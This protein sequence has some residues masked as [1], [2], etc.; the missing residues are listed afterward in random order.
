MSSAL[1]VATEVR[2]GDVT[3]LDL[4]PPPSPTESER[5]LRIAEYPFG[6]NAFFSDAIAAARNVF[7]GQVLLSDGSTP[8]WCA[9]V[10]YFQPGDNEPK[11]ARTTDALGQFRPRGTWWMNIPAKP[12]EL[13]GPSEPVVVAFLPGTCG[14]AILPPPERSDQPMRIV[15]PPPIAQ[16]GQVKVGG[17]APTQ[18]NGTIHVKAGY[19]DKGFLNELLSVTTTA[20][21]D[22]NFTLA[23]L[24]PGNYLIQAALDDIWLSPSSA[25]HVTKG[26]PEPIELNIPPPGTPVV[27]RLVDKNGTPRIGEKLTIDRASGPLAES[28]WPQEWTSDG[29][30]VVN[31][32][33]L[34]AGK[35]VLHASTRMLSQ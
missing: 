3:H 10:L 25:V 15:L 19:Q 6:R 29:L 1:V 31:I 13:Q 17:G 20:D 4:T 33:T 14:A 7:N 26:N 5:T 9:Q 18:L 8:A 34:E 28:L 23:G 2:G 11:Q 16:R 22:G 35:H 24:T 12:G 32:P 21:L 30:G 27:M